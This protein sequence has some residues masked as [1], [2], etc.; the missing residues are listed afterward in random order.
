MHHPMMRRGDT[1][2]QVRDV[3]QRLEDLGSVIGDP[4]G[5]FGAATQ[6]AVR[7]FQQ[8]RGL[9]ADGTVGSDTW[10]SLTEAG[11]RLGDRLLYRS[12]PPMRGD[13]IRELQDRLDR[14]GL[15]VGPSDGIYGPETE[16]A[17]LEFQTMQGLR[18]D[19]QAGAVAIEALRR[20][21][22]AHQLVS[23]AVVRERHRT[24][25]AQ[26]R[27][28]SIQGAVVVIDP[29]NSPDYPGHENPDGVPEHE[30]TWAIALQ[31]QGRMAAM[32][33]RAVLARGPH[34]SPSPSVRA[35]LANDQ[36][37]DL[38][39]SIHANGLDSSTARGVAAYYFGN[40]NGLSETGRELAELIVCR[41]ARHLPSPDCR[42]HPSTA[43]LLR[44]TSAPCVAVEVGFLTHPE[45]GRGLT[46][47]GHQT[48]ITDV[49][50]TA[51]ADWFAGRIAEVSNTPLPA[52]PLA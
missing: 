36:G 39:V 46:D 7:A 20:V 32:G 27:P 15:D 41:L 33:A 21:G 14:L 37:A 23:A 25:G 44:E 47:P 34:N 52:V 43:T 12:S 10:R 29:G 11:V 24:T 19:G 26:P 30:V 50:A 3:Q 48:R 13:D 35:A 5:T 4:P 49:L 42:A 16:A 45:E 18:P 40:P 51:T 28:T 6:A 31:L 9:F 38:V 8:G 17:V 1:G 2:P 22:R